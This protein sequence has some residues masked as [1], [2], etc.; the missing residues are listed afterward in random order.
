MDD[1][2]MRNDG[3]AQLVIGD[4]TVRFYDSGEVD[5]G[6]PTL[7]WHHGTPQTGRLLPPVV[8]AAA[9]RG[10]RV[11]SVAR[12][13]YEGTSP[14]PGRSVADSAGDVLA[15]A[16]ALGIGVFAAVGA[17]GGG[18]HALACA[19]IA[20]E[21]VSVV[22]A[23]AAIAPYT[24]DFDWFDGMASDGAVR[25]ARV[26]RAARA[27][28]AETAEF[29]PDSFVAA[30]W[31]ALEAE[32]GPLGAD[33]GRA[34]AAHPA[35][36]IDDDVAYTTPWGATLAEVASPVLLVQGSLD[37]VVPAAHAAWML[38]RLPAA[39]LW[40]RPRDGHVSVLR[41]LPVALDWVRETAG[42]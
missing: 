17:S 36:E 1:E 3:G 5:P 16:D 21:R 25:A 7:F 20:P 11:V 8:S 38:G 10:M 33:A 14:L 9:R 13:S 30:D 34:G 42:R 19:A 2:A 37:R 27:R 26:G 18:A 39:E 23:F 40:V 24:E 4:R 22:A 12:P 35:G 29:D 6:G 32:W 28:Y 41:A 31:A 15:V